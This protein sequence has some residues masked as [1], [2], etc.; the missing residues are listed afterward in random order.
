MATLGKRISFLEGATLKE[1]RRRPLNRKT[2]ATPSE[3]RLNNVHSAT[4][5]S[6]QPWAR[7]SQRFQRTSFLS[8][9]IEPT[10]T[11]ATTRSHQHRSRSSTL[12]SVEQGAVHEGVA[13]ELANQLVLIGGGCIRVCMTTQYCSVFSFS[14]SNCSCVACGALISN[15]A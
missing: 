8:V 12:S 7:I 5:G 2:A 1:L 9:L 6:K 3:L 11:H 14:A 15:L 10:N 13:A 4:Q